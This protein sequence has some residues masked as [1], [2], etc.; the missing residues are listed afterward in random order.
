MSEKVIVE[1][2]KISKAYK[3]YASHLTPR[4]VDIITKYY[5]IG[6]NVRHTLRELG[7]QYEVTRERI[8][9]IKFYGLVKIK[10][11]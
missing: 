4:E 2:A 10:M 11:K 5:G 6:N 9:Q 7:E 3:K 1:A 8:R